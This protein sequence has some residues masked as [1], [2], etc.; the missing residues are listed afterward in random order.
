[1][2]RAAG[3]RLVYRWQNLQTK[4]STQCARPAR[5]DSG[6]SAAASIGIKK[7]LQPE[8][9]VFVSTIVKAAAVQISPV[10]YRNPEGNHQ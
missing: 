1:V 5:T 7:R 6:V 8:R 2:R 3:S 10:L 4:P 9:K